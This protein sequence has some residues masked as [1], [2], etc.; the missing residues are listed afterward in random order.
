MEI[1][2]LIISG[3]DVFFLLLLFFFVLFCLKEKPFVWNQIYERLNSLRW[4]NVPIQKCVVLWIRALESS[5]KFPKFLHLEILTY[6]LYDTNILDRIKR[7][8]LNINGV[9]TEHDHPLKESKFQKQLQ[10]L[11]RNHCA[12]FISKIHFN[13]YNHFKKIQN[14]FPFLNQFLLLRTNVIILRY[15]STRKSMHNILINFSL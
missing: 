12:L 13:W 10:T 9:I 4:P 6:I 8:V 1:D 2:L 3:G 14:R 5:S 7:D 11:Y 15:V